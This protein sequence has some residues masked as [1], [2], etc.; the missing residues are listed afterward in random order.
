MKSVALRQSSLGLSRR[1]TPALTNLNLE[2][3]YAVMKAN[4]QTASGTSSRP[5][6]IS[7][8][9]AAWDAIKNTGV[10]SLRG[11]SSMSDEWDAIK[12]IRAK[13]KSRFDNL[14]KHLQPRPDDPSSS[15]PWQLIVNA[16]DEP[17]S[18]SLR[19]ENAK[20]MERDPAG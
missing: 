3:A 6:P 9:K 18:R 12:H 7:D 15:D 17:W 10:G 11:S 19:M 4:T 14:D 16:H 2:Q 20:R 1:L 13:D 8:E 5:D